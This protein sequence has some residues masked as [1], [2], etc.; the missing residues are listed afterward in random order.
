[1]HNVYGFG[2]DGARKVVLCVGIVCP[3]MKEN[4]RKHNT[5]VLFH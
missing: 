3:G 4:R 1:M 2:D 5:D